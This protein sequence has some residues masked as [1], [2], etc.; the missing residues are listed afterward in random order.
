MGRIDSHDQSREKC[1]HAD[2]DLIARLREVGAWLGEHGKGLGETSREIPGESVL[3]ALQRLARVVRRMPVPETG[4]R[5][6]GPRSIRCLM[7]GLVMPASVSAPA[8]R[9][10]AVASTSAASA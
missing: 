9:G 4:Q 1:R 7:V 8:A 3:P 6:K 5:A 10:R 2:A